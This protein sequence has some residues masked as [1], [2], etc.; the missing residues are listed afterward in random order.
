[1][2][3]QKLVKETLEI[4]ER[5]GS[6]DR[7]ENLNVVAMVMGA[8]FSY[9]SQQ[10]NPKDCTEI[11]DRA[12][13]MIGWKPEYETG[14]RNEEPPTD[15]TVIYGVSYGPYKYKHY[16]PNSQERKRGKLGRWQAMNEYGG[17]NNAEPPHQWLT[18][19]EFNAI[20]QGKIRHVSIKY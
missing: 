4:F 11:V 19:Q 12:Q 14:W 15:G 5:H 17:W 10:A 13:K 1:M 20:A 2:D 18:E 7:M 3:K 16:K 9:L 6:D 8:V